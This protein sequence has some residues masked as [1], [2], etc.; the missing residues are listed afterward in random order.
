MESKTIEKYG[1]YYE[2]LDG[3]GQCMCQYN[4]NGKKCWVTWTSMAYR[5][6]GKIYC[7][8]HI[9]EMLQDKR[10][11]RFIRETRKAAMGKTHYKVFTGMSE[12]QNR[13]F[14]TRYNVME[15]VVQNGDDYSTVE[16]VSRKTAY[17]IEKDARYSVI[18]REIKKG[19][20]IVY[21]S[22]I[23]CLKDDKTTHYNREGI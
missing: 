6:D 2:K 14:R 16:V 3:N 21:R 7:S 12:E 10:D 1:L 13:I 8:Q 20:R 23:V 19:R 5:L 17:T 15:K 18:I 4:K 11:E 22:I 9:D